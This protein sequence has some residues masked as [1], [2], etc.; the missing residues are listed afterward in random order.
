[1]QQKMKK[2]CG[3]CASCVP[4]TEGDVLKNPDPKICKQMACTIHR[5]VVGIQTK[6][7][8][9]FRMSERKEVRELRRTGLRKLRL[10]FWNCLACPYCTSHSTRRVTK[11]RLASHY[12]CSHPS[13]PGDDAGD[14]TLTMVITTIPNWCPLPYVLKT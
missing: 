4:I 12:Y 5:K 11:G 6:A 10:E 9:F 8:S 7:C 3:L 14:N 13:L 2:R 1:M